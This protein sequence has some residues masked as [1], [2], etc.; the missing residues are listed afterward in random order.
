MKR[1]VHLFISGNVHGV[2]FRSFIKQHAD[3]LAITGFVCNT[4]DFKVEAVAEGESRALNKLIDL[5]KKG[6]KFAVVEDVR[7]V[8]EQFR[9]GYRGFAVLH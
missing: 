5:C 9:G 4:P 3:T 7:V 1:R 8:E 2:F 6:P